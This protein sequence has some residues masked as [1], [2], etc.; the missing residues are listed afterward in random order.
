MTI[1]VPGLNPFHTIIKRISRIDTG[2]QYDVI[3]RLR[4][5]MARS[6]NNNPEL[7]GVY[8]PA[9]TIVNNNTDDTTLTQQLTPHDNRSQIAWTGGRLYTSSSTK[10]GYIV[11]NN[12]Y[13]A[14]GNATAVIAA[15]VTPPFLN[16]G[17]NIQSCYTFWFETDAPKFQLNIP[18]TVNSPIRIIVD[19]QYLTTTGWDTSTNNYVSVD[20]T[21][22][23]PRTIG[24]DCN[25][26]VQFR[27]M[28]VDGLSRVWK[29][30]P[31]ED[32][33]AIFTGDSHL[34]GTIVGV[35]ALAGHLV[36][37]LCGIWD[38]RTAAVPSTGYLADASGARQNIFGQMDAWINE[39]TYDLIG[40]AGGFNDTA[41][42]LATAAD[43]A[44]ACWRK[45][46]G[47]QPNAFIVVFGV[48][49]TNTGPGANNIALENLLSARFATWADPFSAF[50][51][52][53]TDVQPWEYG[54]GSISAPVGDGNS[55][56]YTNTSDLPH[57][58]IVGQQ[59]RGLRMA[60]AI[61]NAVFSI[62]A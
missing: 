35:P 16:V 33:K 45:A 48:W 8:S 18:S 20:F 56:L 24:I 2:G 1:A 46:R 4:T 61:R 6:L 19:G 59:Y 15:T 13:P 32:T 10:R 7:L 34:A 55:D 25:S 28:R 26:V 49:A 42:T 57:Y 30:R 40:F 31:A 50:I 38:C 14:T 43:N 60:N 39:M 12:F 47:A 22:R 9:P 21:T 27:S 37:K 5:S 62:A 58:S 17:E 44:L 41:L 54:T 53:C 36:G 23:K 3:R 29:P 51:P 52:V 11:T